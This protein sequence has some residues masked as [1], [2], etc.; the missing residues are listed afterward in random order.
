MYDVNIKYSNLKGE[1]K[2]LFISTDFFLYFIFIV[3]GIQI[4]VPGVLLSEKRMS[5]KS[6]NDTPLFHEGSQQAN[7]LV[8]S[9]KETALITKK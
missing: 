4:W 8:L 7:M 1:R 5:P 3:A 9:M 2:K 6:A